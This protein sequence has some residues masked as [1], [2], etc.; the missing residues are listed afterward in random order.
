MDPNVNHVCQSKAK[1]VTFKVTIFGILQNHFLYHLYIVVTLQ[2]PLSE[3]LAHF[4]RAHL[5]MNWSNEPVNT[6]D[7]TETYHHHHPHG[8]HTALSRD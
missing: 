7:L 1:Y 2:G 4:Q 6:L 3:A 5:C 8:Q